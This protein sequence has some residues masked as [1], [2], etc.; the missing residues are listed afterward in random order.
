MNQKVCIVTGANAGIGKQAAIQLANEGAHVIIACRNEERGRKALAEI[1]RQINGGSAELRLLDMASQHSIRMFAEQINRDLP[2][3]DVLIHNAADFNIARK[4]AEYSLEG[5]ETVWATNHVGPVL[6]TDLLLGALK[7]SQDGRV[8]TVSSKGLLVKFNTKVDIDDPEFKQRKYT[9]TNAYY[10]SKRAQEMYTLWLAEQLKGTSVT[11]NC[12]R[13]TNVKIDISRYPD[14]SAFMRFM[15]SIKSK[16]SIT[17]VQM[18]R[19][20][21]HLALSDDVK[22]ISGKC[23]DENNKQVSMNSYTTDAAN[24]E[25][26]MKLTM[27]Y[28]KQ[29]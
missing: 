18:A 28:I 23:F 19:T 25:A 29:Q 15:Y 21:A 14:L 8:I 3:V 9:V 11:A 2:R 7:R 5:I 24:I 13:V 10:Q 6:L 1:Q 27:Q 22:S 26:V 12:I 17:A 16:K 20:Y 4:Q